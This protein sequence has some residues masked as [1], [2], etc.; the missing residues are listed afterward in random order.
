MILVTSQ[1]NFAAEGRYSKAAST[2][3]GMDAGSLGAL[4]SPCFPSGRPKRRGTSH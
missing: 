2:R 3:I 4:S 1:M